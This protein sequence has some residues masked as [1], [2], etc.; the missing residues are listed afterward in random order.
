MEQKGSFHGEEPRRELRNRFPRLDDIWERL[1]DPS[2]STPQL[3]QIISS[4]NKDILFRGVPVTSADLEIELPNG[5]MV[6]VQ[7]DPDVPE[8]YALHRVG[9]Q[10]E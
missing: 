6:E 5:Q 2:L 4:F 1:M 8:N 10:N 3:E 7:W 9:A